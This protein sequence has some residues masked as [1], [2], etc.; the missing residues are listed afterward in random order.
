MCSFFMVICTENRI[1]PFKHIMPI[2][3]VVHL[4]GDPK[5]KTTLEF[6]IQKEG[7]N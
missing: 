5:S 1:K 6:K 2:F 4:N 7:G 3:F